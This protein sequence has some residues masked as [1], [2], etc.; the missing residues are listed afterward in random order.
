[1]RISFEIE[2]GFKETYYQFKRWITAEI[3]KRK[4]HTWEKYKEPAYFWDAIVLNDAL[5]G[6]ITH[7]CKRCQEVKRKKTV[8]TI[9][10][11]RYATRA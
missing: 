3:C 5:G 1:M 4:G 7:R 9:R 11:K 6:K 10:F 8:K 2:I